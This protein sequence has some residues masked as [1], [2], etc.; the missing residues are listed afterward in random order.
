[1]PPSTSALALL[2]REFLGIR[3]RVVELAA[4][5]DRVERGH[6]SAAADPRMA[7]IRGA[8]EILLTPEANRA[9]QVQMVFSLPYNDDWRTA[10]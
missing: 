4:A 3:S 7:Q 6:G 10:T 9:E 5:L 1:M 2:E 8:L